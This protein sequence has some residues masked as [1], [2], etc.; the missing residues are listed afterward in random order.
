VNQPPFTTDSAAT[1]VGAAWGDYDNDG[2]LDLYIVNGNF[3]SVQRRNYLY[4]NNG[5]GTFTKVGT[6]SVAIDYGSAT[7]AAWED[8]DNDGNLDLFVSQNTG[9]GT[10]RNNVLYH[11]NGDG[12][13]TRLAAHDLVADAGHFDSAAWGDIDNDGFPDLFVAAGVT[14][15]LLYHNQGNSNAW[16][17]FKLVGTVSNR[18]A[19]GAK[20]R[21]KATIRGNTYWQ[22]REISNGDGL[23]GNNLR[24]HFGLGDATEADTVR[25]EWPSRTVQEFRHVAARQILTI[26]EPALLLA[27]IT[28]GVPQFSIKGGRNLQYEVDS[29]TNLLNWSSVGTVTITNFDSTAVITNPNPTG[30][31]RLFYRAVLH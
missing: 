17:T 6:G 27:T 12:T 24:A 25:I 28:N 31:G 19:I 29:S 13:F 21:V 15:S 11:N 2:F 30:S 1:S 4:R 20:V 9:S 3:D 7:T 10:A 14:P 8:F 16:V 26:T 18:S 5:N 23:A 22:M